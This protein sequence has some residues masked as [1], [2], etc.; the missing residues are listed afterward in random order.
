MKKFLNS[1]YLFLAGL[2]VLLLF[3]V[4]HNLHVNEAN[5]SSDVWAYQ[6][7]I[8]QEKTGDWSYVPPDYK[9][10]NYYL[11]YDILYYLSPN[12][13]SGILGYHLMAMFIII[14]TYVISG[15]IIKKIFN[16]WTLATLGALLTIVPRYIFPTRIGILDIGNVRGNAFVF[17]FYFLLSYYWI[18]YGIKKKW[19]NILLGAIGGFLVYIYPLVGSVIVAFYILI[20]LIIYKKEY[21]KQVVY[22]A[23]AYL[24]ISLPFWIN[25]FFNPEAGML[26]V[27]NNMSTEDLRLQA[28]IVRYRFQANAFLSTVDIARVKR[29]LWDGF[30]LFG[31]FFASLFFYKKYFS[32]LRE[33]YRLTFKTSAL[34]VF[35]M[36]A[37]ILGVEVLNH[38]ADQAG[39]PPYFVEH[40]RLMRATG[41]ALIMHFILVIYVLYKKLNKKIIAIILSLF[42]LFS[43]IYFAAPVI[44]DVVRLVV[45]E[46]IRL[47]YNLAPIVDADDV[48]AFDNIKDVSAWAKENIEEDA[49]FFVF[50][51]F[52]NEFRFKFLSR[53]DTNLTAKEGAIYIT[54]NFKD[55]KWWY[56]E[57]MAYKDRVE[58]AENFSQIVDFAKELGSTHILLPRGKYSELY[59]ESEVDNVSVLY[60]NYDYRI[61]KID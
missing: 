24:I 20:A 37:F 34:F 15:L 52:Q 39:K 33:K 19:V 17:P 27:S 23:L 60:S 36:I 51:D 4:F 46:S 61:L 13:E 48:R 18:I 10:S 26:N 31:V 28:E 47:K 57:R 11:T 25:F 50:D 38:L 12:F 8:S 55:S 54:S 1:K 44:R 32:E 16:S 45:P 9:N 43:P 14:A 21:F 56:E 35:I 6:L 49:R 40:L 58:P 5:V 30:V 2:L 59:D 42:V 29:S 3:Y 41:Y 22:F 53:H 7:I